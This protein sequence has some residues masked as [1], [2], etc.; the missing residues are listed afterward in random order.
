MSRENLDPLAVR[1][2]ELFRATDEAGHGVVVRRPVPILFFGDSRAYF[3]SPMKAVT[4]GLNPSKIEFDSADPFHRFPLARGV[5]PDD[6]TR[7]L[8]SLDAYFKED[9][10]RSWFNCYEPLLQGLGVSYY[11]GGAGQ[12]TLVAPD[13]ISTQSPNHALPCRAGTDVAERR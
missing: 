10:Y 3:D 6:E 4:V 12:A 1:A 7:Y 5:Q 11:S 8:D 9:P 13:G 2:W